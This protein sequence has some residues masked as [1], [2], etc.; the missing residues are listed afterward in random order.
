MAKWRKII[1]DVQENPKRTFI[2]YVNDTSGL[3]IDILKIQKVTNGIGSVSDKAVLTFYFRD[4]AEKTGR[5]LEKLDDANLL[6]SMGPFAD[7]GKTIELPFG[8]L[9]GKSTKKL[10]NDLLDIVLKEN[11]Q[12][13]S[14]EVRQDILREFGKNLSVSSSSSQS[15][16]SSSDIAI[17]YAN[18]QQSILLSKPMVD[19]N[20]DDS[21]SDDDKSSNDD[22]N[23]DNLGNYPSLSD[24]R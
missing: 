17:S 14:A 5:L 15:S 1:T 19:I 9:G 23:D 13:N 4:N 12:E 2:K 6:D 20:D 24:M 7:E 3:N 21:S 18:S 22:D 8:F 16:T 11:E 10:V